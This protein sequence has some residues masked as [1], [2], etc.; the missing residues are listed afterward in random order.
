MTAKEYLHEIK[1]IRRRVNLLQAE[2]SR[3]RTDA[4]SV[5]INLDGMPKGKSGRSWENLAVQLAECESTLQSE[6]SL[7]WSKQM[8]AV[9]LIG[10]LKPKHQMIL[11]EYYIAD[12]TWERIAYEQDIT[13]RHCYR[14][15][16]SALAEFERVL[17]NEDIYILGRQ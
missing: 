2:V 11:T 3:L 17:Q 7:L 15:H 14:L 10:R 6:L 16:G 13:W 5:S 9:E 4:E 12:K 1:K 8:Q